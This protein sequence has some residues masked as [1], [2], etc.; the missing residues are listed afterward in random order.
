MLELHE[1]SLVKPLR[2]DSWKDFFA[3]SDGTEGFLNQ[4]LALY[5][6]WLQNDKFCNWFVSNPK[7][8]LISESGNLTSMGSNA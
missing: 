4:Q 5:E 7:L 8:G 3:V 2:W 6:Y 1:G